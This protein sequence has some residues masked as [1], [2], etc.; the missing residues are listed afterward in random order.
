MVD[1]ETATVTGNGSYSTP[2]GYLP[3]AAGT[4]QWVASYAGDTNNN[5]AASTK[6]S[7]PEVVSLASPTISTT[8]GGTVVVGSGSKLTDSATVSGG[9]NPTGTITFTLYA[10]NGT[11][12][13][14]TET[15]TV[16]GNGRYI[17]AERISADGGGTYQWVASYSG[18]TNNNPVS[19]TK[20]SE[21][22]NV[23]ARRTRLS[24][25]PRGHSRPGQRQQADRLGHARR[26]AT[27]RPAR[28]PSR[29]TPQRHDSRRHRNGDGQRQRHLQH[30]ERLPAHATGTYQWV[31]SYGGDSNNNSGEHQRK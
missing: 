5:S 7:E 30:A 21:P 18:D 28:S 17:D 10:P 12:V 24:P 3:T 16:N 27:T 2:N 15:V 1:T 13:V 23:S 9:Y 4:Y 29:F 8:A 11:T 14:D 6:G 22:E 26:A 19:T 25:R 20:G 31:V